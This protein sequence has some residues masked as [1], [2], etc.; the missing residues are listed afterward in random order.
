MYLLEFFL[1]TFWLLILPLLIGSIVVNQLIKEEKPDI[2]LTMVCGFVCMLALFYI[3]VIPMLFLKLPLHV[4]IYFWGILMI[5]LCGIAL[6][7]NRKRYKE[8]IF[9]IIES[10]KK[11]TWFSLLI[12]I[13]ILLQ[14]FVLVYYMHSDADDA[15]YVANATTSVATDSIFLYD[16]YTGIPFSEYPGRHVL[17]PFP[18]FVALISKLVLIH[19]TIVA[20]TILPA[21]LI[22]ISYM[23]F[24][25]LGRK[26]FP[27]QPSGVLFFLLF[28]SV[29]NI[30]GNF[31]IY[32]NSTFLL[33]RIWQGKAVLANI[34]IPAITYFSY[35]AMYGEKKMGDWIM[36]LVCAIMA[37]LVS[38]MGIIM[39]PVMIVCLGVIFAIRNKKIRIFAYSI[40]CCM[41]CLAVGIFSIII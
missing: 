35:R 38:S 30:F 37:C 18:I 22:P 16:P 39:A 8:I 15:F 36:L 14:S 10:T 11:I 7:I 28:L 9:S 12:I 34:V 32:T 26:F 25:L 6:I 13:L 27:N 4:L 23:L 33:F 21:I 2:M 5:F 40:A 20:H 1:I 31:S 29:L 17:S 3:L 41:P 19:P 24:F